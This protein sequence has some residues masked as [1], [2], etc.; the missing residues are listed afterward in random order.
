[1]TRKDYIKIANAIKNNTT[2]THKLV[3]QDFILE[4][5]NIFEADNPNFDRSRF[6]LACGGATPFLP[7]EQD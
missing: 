6:Y 4:L 3:K 1:V 7:D 5:C 2:A